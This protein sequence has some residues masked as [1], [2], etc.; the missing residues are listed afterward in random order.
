MKRI[1]ILLI[2]AT[3][4]NFGFAQDKLGFGNMPDGVDSAGFGTVTTW[5]KKA[6]NEIW[7]TEIVEVTSSVT[8]RIWMDRN[9]G[10][11]RAATSSVD[12]DSYGYLFQWGRNPD[13]H[14]IRTSDTTNVLSETDTPIDGDFIISS[15][16]PYDWR[17]PQNDNLWQSAIQGEWR[18]PTSAEFEAERVGWVSNNAEGAYGSTLKITV[19]GYRT[20]SGNGSIIAS[21]TI[22]YYWTKDTNGIYTNTLWVT[23]TNAVS[24]LISYRGRGASVRLIKD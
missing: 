7:G 17:T 16:V 21:G 19:G 20:P 4:I 8:G 13:G 2:L 14:E 12:S 5:V 6:S 10:A 11:L 22:C 3:S 9:I 23:T 1:L 18:L 15:S 24:N